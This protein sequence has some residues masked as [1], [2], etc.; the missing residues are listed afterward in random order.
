M[1]GTIVKTGEMVQ[2]SGFYKSIN[3]EH[4]LE[5]DFSK[6]E[7]ATSCHECHKSVIWKLRREDGSHSTCEKVNVLGTRHVPLK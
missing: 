6:G 5:R 3:C 2:V 1:S 7:I 4:T